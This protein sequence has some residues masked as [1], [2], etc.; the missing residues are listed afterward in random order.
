[1]A[2]GRSVIEEKIGL[3]LVDPSQELQR[4]YGLENSRGALVSA[5]TPGSPAAAA[6]LQVGDLIIEANGR[7]VEDVA[8]LRRVATKVPAGEAL[9]LLLQRRNLLLYTV[10]KVP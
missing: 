7:V 4:R 1:V 2:E 6:G 10:I 8:G 3:G 5:V 9:R